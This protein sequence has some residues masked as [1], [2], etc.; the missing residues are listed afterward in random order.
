M[1]DESNSFTSIVVAITIVDFSRSSRGFLD[2]FSNTSMMEEVDSS[3]VKS[4]T[5][6]AL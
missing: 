3:D 1:V 2:L 5:L 6:Q 4:L